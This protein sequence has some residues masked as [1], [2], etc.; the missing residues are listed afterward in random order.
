MPLELSI[1]VS[2]GRTAPVSHRWRTAASA[3]S[4]FIVSNRR[5]TSPLP[6]STRS[7]L[8]I[9]S[10]MWLSIL[11]L[12]HTR[13]GPKDPGH[14]DAAVPQAAHAVAHALGQVR[15]RGVEEH[16]GDVAA[17]GDLHPGAAAAA[18]GLLQEA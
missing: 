10:E 16:T 17:V 3:D 9:A 1:R 2:P 7:G 14:G 6:R 4:A 8:P 18:G 5:Q 11:T 15:G 12:R 13:G